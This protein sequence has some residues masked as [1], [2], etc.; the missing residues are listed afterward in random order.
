MVNNI[1]TFDQQWAE[2]FSGKL[3]MVLSR[4]D[5]I[6]SMLFYN[7]DVLTADEAAM[8]LGLTKS[9]FYKVVRKYG[10][11]CSRPTHG[12]KYFLR[13]D[14]EAWLKSRTEDTAS[15]DIIPEMYL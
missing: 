3:D 8:Y 4:L 9:S 14:L 2:Q 7:K 15:T 10:I 6:V 13:T 11:K 12:K 5:N 1:I